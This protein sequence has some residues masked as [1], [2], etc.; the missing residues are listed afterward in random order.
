MIGRRRVM[1]YGIAG[2]L[3]AIG[4]GSGLV[5]RSVARSVRPDTGRVDASPSRVSEPAPAP[6]F[7]TAPARGVLERL[8]AGHAD[9]I[10]LL[11]VRAADDVERYRIRTSVLA[12]VTVEGTSI[13]ALLAG[14][15]WYLKY[16][17]D[18]TVS[19]PGDSLGR[20]PAVLPTPRAPI[21]GAAAVKHRFALNDTE[22]GYAGAYR[23][24]A[25]WERTL[26]VLALHGFT[27]VL[28][29]AGQDEVY[30]RVFAEFGYRPDEL[31]AWIPAASYQPWW[32]LGNLQGFD[33]PEDPAVRQAGVTVVQQAADRLRELGL[34]PVLPGYLGEVPP[35]FARR[36]AGARVLGQGIWNGYQRPDWLDPR[37]PHF[38][39]I[40]ESFYR[41]QADLY[42]RGTAY[43]MDLLH[44][45][46][47]S[48]GVPM[49]DAAVAVM[50]A[51][52]TARPGATWVMLGWD[53]NPRRDVLDALRNCAPAV[54]ARSEV[55]IIDGCSDRFAAFDREADWDGTAY[56]FGTIPNF[57]G[58]SLLG[59]NA[60]TWSDRYSKALAAN[61]TA[62]SGI[63]WL[64]E[65]SSHD[66][67]AFEL[68]A[69]L[70][71]RP[72]PF[73]LSDWFAHYAAR[74]YG[75]VDAAATQAWQTFAQTAYSLPPGTYSQA[76]DSLFTAWPDLSA[77]SAV[78]GGPEM[79]YDATSFQSAVGMLLQA[80]PALRTIDAYRYDI[81]DFTRQA[82]ANHARVLLPK[83]KAAY[84]GHDLPGFHTLT[85][86]WLNAMTLL[87][88]LL[89]TDERFL[90]GTWL[91]SGGHDARALITTWGGRT[92]AASLHDYGGRELSGLIADV[93]VP[94]WHRHFAA[95][96]PVVAGTAKTWAQTDWF[97]MDDAWARSGKAYPVTAVG[98][99][100]A[101]ANDV[102]AFLAA[103]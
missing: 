73:D 79:R 50:T 82:L 39:R 35:G 5:A 37:D 94:R 25:E 85:G 15:G 46:G 68:F 10:E 103:F 29:P 64:P 96:E 40:A 7:D 3:G 12:A 67:A 60:A 89:A 47:N 95:L 26:D 53:G 45:G 76:Q 20:L 54:C 31:D 44:E 51:L 62:L 16:V 81:V 27:E 32:L 24:W 84:T 13:A 78:A 41:H 63:A 93:Y 30:R 71:W 87:D 92:P 102:M 14:V 86:R 74:R 80:D 6:P 33:A 77:T 88:T 21:S 52:Q 56:A 42:G 97:A 36:N 4:V 101:V 34:T 57:G 17:A 38:A 28:I 90:L 11:A 48:G 69:E 43:K 99:P 70:A 58:R 1:G 75:T 18:V 22:N 9:Q 83:I 23:S 65:A 59:A 61:G 91:R 55:L 72:D 19:L 49:G 2:T 66:P 100:F 8:L 98:D